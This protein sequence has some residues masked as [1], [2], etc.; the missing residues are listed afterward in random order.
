LNG[1]GFIVKNGELQNFI[2]DLRISGDILKDISSIDYI[3]KDFDMFGNYCEKFGQFVRVG[4]GGPTIS[5]S[6]LN[7][8][9]VLYG[10]R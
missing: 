5:I 2:G 4:S 8:R 10:R 1:N 9:G 3:G 7:A 6:S